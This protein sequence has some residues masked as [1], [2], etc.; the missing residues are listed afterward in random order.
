MFNAIKDI[1]NYESE[2]NSN[3][4]NDIIMRE[5]QIEFKKIFFETQNKT[6][7]INIISK[8]DN[9]TINIQPIPF[10]YQSSYFKPVTNKESLIKFTEQ[11]NQ[12]NHY[13]EVL[14]PTV[15][16][17]N[18]KIMINTKK[19]YIFKIYDKNLI[20]KYKNLQTILT[21]CLE[22]GKES[23]LINCS[24]F[25]GKLICLICSLKYDLKDLHDPIPKLVNNDVNNSIKCNRCKVKK[26][27]CLFVAHSGRSNLH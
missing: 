19:N 23:K 22:C 21:R 18:E 13:K 25:S 17:K 27:K 1:T 16:V 6:S 24:E 8:D 15:K 14:L 9:K 3:D 10:S 2:T 7:K 4:I 26:F 12:Q 20:E 11:L 5:R